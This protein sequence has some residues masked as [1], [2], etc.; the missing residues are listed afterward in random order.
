MIST[1]KL[2]SQI[3][4][5]KTQLFNPKDG[6]CWVKFS[7]LKLCKIKL[8]LRRKKDGSKD[9]ILIFQDF[10]W[11]TVNYLKYM[12]IKWRDF[13]YW[14]CLVHPASSVGNVVTFD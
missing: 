7:T 14:C 4:K 8:K 6:N 12:A 11:K 3:G 2:Y 1:V 10:S 9:L 13:N 5:N